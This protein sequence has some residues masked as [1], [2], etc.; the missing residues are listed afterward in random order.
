MN[1]NGISL[2]EVLLG[3]LMLSLGLSAAARLHANLASEADA[4]RHRT[5]ATFLAQQAME[6]LRTPEHG[7]FA[8]AILTPSSQAYTVLPEVDTTDWLQPT[9]VTVRWTD[10]Q[11][12]TQQ[13]LF[14]SY[15]F[16]MSPIYSAW[17]AQPR[18]VNS[19]IGLPFD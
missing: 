16:A 5:E 2:I 19:P 12:Q 10:R 7:D 6:R 3:V 9:Q 14:S 1:Q 8:E 17:L 4:A 13:L 18:P 11:G 15:R